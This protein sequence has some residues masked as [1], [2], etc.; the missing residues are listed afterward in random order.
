MKQKHFKDTNETVFPSSFLDYKD[1]LRTYYAHLKLLVGRYSYFQFADDVGFGATGIIH[2]MIQGRRALTR[3]NGS[4][5]AEGLGIKGIE[6]RYL[7]L[8]IEYTNLR[9]PAQR[10]T[11]FQR[12]WQLKR[13][14]IKDA[15]DQATLEYFSQWYHPVIREMTAFDDFSSDPEWISR[16]LVPHVSPQ[17]AAESLALLERL[18]LI[19]FDPATGRHELASGTVHAGHEVMGHGFVSYHQQMIQLGGESLTRTHASDREISGVTLRLSRTAREK[20]RSMVHQFSMQ[21]L[22]EANED[23]GESLEVF[24]LNI[25]LFPVTKGDK[26]KS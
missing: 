22:N 17:E 25:Q 21:A 23:Q 6:R 5:L 2:Q 24:Q 15:H 14:T 18:E 3:H 12:M 13:E 9:A 4:K 11:V 20:L 19:Q 10:Q 8:L 1:Y 16:R 26:E 7:L